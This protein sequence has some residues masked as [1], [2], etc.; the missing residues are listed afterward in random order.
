MS[1][2]I[3]LVR[4]TYLQHANHE[5]IISSMYTVLHPDILKKFKIANGHFKVKTRTISPLCFVGVGVKI[6]IEIWNLCVF[7]FLYQA[8]QYRT[9]F[10]EVFFKP[11]LACPYN[12]ILL[13][14]CWN[15]TLG[16]TRNKPSNILRLTKCL[17][18]IYDV[19]K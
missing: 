12:Y 5:H 9:E 17:L 13:A 2:P 14:T 3:I 6:D 10:P 4:W 15:M 16:Q 19:L 7:I 8:L 11:H 18:L 1:W